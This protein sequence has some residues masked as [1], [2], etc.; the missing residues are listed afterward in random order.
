M[1][2]RQ[3]QLSVRQA[4]VRLTLQRRWSGWDSGAKRQEA[5]GGNGSLVLQQPLAGGGTHTTDSPTQHIR[6][7]PPDMDGSYQ[8]HA[9]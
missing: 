1:S 7:L 6:P 3:L 2:L 8:H 5:R 4:A 9:G